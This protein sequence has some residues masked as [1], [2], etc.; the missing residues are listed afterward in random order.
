[1]LD[2]F[3]RYIPLQFIL[4]WL[5]IIVLL[6]AASWRLHDLE[7]QSLWND[8]GTALRV[9][10]RD[11][12]DLLDA[13][14]QDIH[15]P[16]YY[17]ALKAW[18]SVA[19][20]S[21]FGLRSLSAFYGIIAVAATYAM[22]ARLYARSAGILAALM[23]AVNAFAVFYSQEARMYAQLAMLAV[24]SMWLLVLLTQSQRPLRILILL[25]GVNVLGLY[26]HYTYPF[27]MIVQGLFFLWY[28]LRNRRH[29][30]PYVV[31]N[32]VTIV[33]FLP[34]LPTA[35]DQITTWPA[36]N[37]EATLTEQIETIAIHLTFGNTAQDIQLL[38][39][40]WLAVL[41]VALVLPDYYRQPPKHTWRVALP[42]A[43]ILVVCGGFL[44]SGSYRETNLKFLLPAQIALAIIIGR[45]VYYLWDIGA[46]SGAL[47]LRIVP[48]LM[49]AAAAFFLFSANLT[50][51]EDI[52]GRF[53]RDNYRDL[54]AYIDANQD[55]DDAVILNAPGQFD[56]FSYYYDD[57]ERVYPLPRGLG[58]DDEATRRETL[59]ILN[60]HGGIFVAF[61]GEGE[62]DPND[63]VRTTL[64]EN[65][66]EV[67]SRWYGD[68]RLV[69]YA[70]LAPP[71]DVAEVETNIAFGED[72]RL[73][74]YALTGEPEAGEAIGVTLFWQTDAVL[75]TRYKVFVQLL[76][77]DGRLVSQHDSEPNNNRSLTIDWQP[78]QIIS[79]NHGLPIPAG[80]AA[81]TYQI[82]VGVYPLD[83]PEQRLMLEDGT[84]FLNV[85][86]L[87]VE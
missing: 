58:G 28:W 33:L 71:P 39:F 82:I 62:R 1:M 6:L 68:V 45:S 9:A 74:G 24:L 31:A 21:E 26:T 14:A 65:A 4:R 67:F 12:P 80:T 37:S 42:V 38:D 76:D 79:D 52:Y 54:A 35:Y 81:G 56:A 73:L 15:P 64:N 16:G 19:G 5:P 2:G 43:W 61:W 11:V 78:G 60:R 69:Q 83:A 50:F 20:E 57:V 75:R 36:A 72:I 49:A 13:T 10:Q 63:V 59:D 18:I 85:A 51:L 34:W 25:T 23:V 44:L 66:Y 3:F 7:A 8:E 87:V 30:L 53:Q 70:V 84:T 40:G 27:T 32:A 22:A 77:D 48:R 41:M 55:A 29:L 17:L 47:P 86:K 46:F